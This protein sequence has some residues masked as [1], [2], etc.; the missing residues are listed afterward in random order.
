M[1]PP[2]W[3]QTWTAPRTWVHGEL[4]TETQL[5]QQIRDNELILKTSISNNGTTWSGNVTLPNAVK[6][7]GT[8]TDNVTVKSLAYIDGANHVIFGDDS[9]ALATYLFGSIINVTTSTHM[10]NASAYR[11][12]ETGGS[13]SRSLA[14]MDGANHVVLGDDS[15][16]RLA[17]LFGSGVNIWPGNVQGLSA[18]SSGGA[19]VGV[20]GTDPGASNFQVIGDLKLGNTHIT[21]SVGTPTIS[22]GFG[23]S[24]P[25]IAGSDYAFRIHVGTGAPTSGVVAF[26]HTWSTAPICTG[27]VVTA[28]PSGV[29]VSLLQ[30]LATQISIQLSAGILVNEEILVLCRGY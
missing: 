14:Y 18:Y 5:N 8:K 13:V 7:S 10:A 24:G 26:G 3:A 21:D 28:T 27:S 12:Y 22:S 17:Y 25:T 23:G 20:G 9:N 30:S 19:S 11:G 4:V 1:A 15:N 29:S 6:V 2:V 16:T